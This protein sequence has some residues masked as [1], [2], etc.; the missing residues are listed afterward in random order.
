MKS[1]RRP[2]FAK[3][4]R[5][6]RWRVRT[7]K[8]LHLSQPVKAA[9]GR[10]Q[11]KFSRGNDAAAVWA[12]Q[13]VQFGFLGFLNLRALV[14]FGGQRKSVFPC[15]LVEEFNPLN[16]RVRVN[17]HFFGCFSSQ[18]NE[19][20]RNEEHHMTSSS[21]FTFQTE[22]HSACRCGSGPGNYWFKIIWELYRPTYS[23]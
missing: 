11:T 10:V 12:A 2:V 18:S 1:H 14:S 15:R 17:C 9:R 3:P 4:A 5:P 7:S 21:L 8:L 20:T 6:G 19:G 13:P 22:T 16:T 23:C